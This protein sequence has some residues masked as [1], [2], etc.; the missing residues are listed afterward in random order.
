MREILFRGIE[1]G[2][3]RF[4]YGDLIQMSNGKRA[5]VECDTFI[6]NSSIDVIPETV[7][8]YTGLKD[9]NGKMIFE[10]DVIEWEINGRKHIA[11]V[12]YFDDGA[13][14]MMNKD[15]ETGFGVFND[16]LRGEYTVLRTIHDDATK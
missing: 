11:P 16:F 3:K 10:W 4:V 6:V 15:V 1:K 14:F 12:E 8:Q 2:T 9:K 13:S 7:G 5:I